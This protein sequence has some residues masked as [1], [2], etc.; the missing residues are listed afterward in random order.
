MIREMACFILKRSFSQSSYTMD[1]I[2]KDNK[3]KQ[4][5]IL[6]C[7]VLGLLIIPSPQPKHYS[8]CLFDECG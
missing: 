7:L 3:M 2:R 6:V 8:I 4:K 5:I 1:L